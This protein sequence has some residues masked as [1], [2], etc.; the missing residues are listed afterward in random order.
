MKWIMQ[1]ADNIFILRKVGV[2][3]PVPGIY[4]YASMYI[5]NGPGWNVLSFSGN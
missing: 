4:E 1:M 2:H 3:V 5:R